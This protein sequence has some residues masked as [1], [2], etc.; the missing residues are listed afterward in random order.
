MPGGT[1]P[2]ANRRSFPRSIR[3]EAEGAFNGQSA[4]VPASKLDSL[5]RQLAAAVH[6]WPLRR[7]ARRTAGPETPSRKNHQPSLEHLRQPPPAREVAE[8]HRVGNVSQQDG[9]RADKE[10]RVERAV[11]VE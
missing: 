5:Q 3:A 2:I 11:L 9:G 1:A 10:P 7:P 6:G 8:H 4:V